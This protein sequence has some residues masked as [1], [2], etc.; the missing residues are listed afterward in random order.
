MKS[1]PFESM[2]RSTLKRLAIAALFVAL[3]LLVAFLES[4]LGLTPNH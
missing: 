2:K 1:N 3:V 4:S